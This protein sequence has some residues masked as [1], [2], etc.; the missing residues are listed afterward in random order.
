MCHLRGTFHVTDGR[1]ASTFGRIK[2]YRNR[3]ETLLY[4][5]KI[6][7]PIV[8]IIFAKKKNFFCVTWNIWRFPEWKKECGCRANI[9]SYTKKKSKKYNQSHSAYGHGRENPLKIIA[10]KTSRRSNADS[11]SIQKKKRQR[12]KKN[13]LG[14]YRS[15]IYHIVR[16]CSRTSH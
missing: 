8:P 9:Y 6:N 2:M 11:F 12:D 10:A 13:E 7:Y 5:W 14:E 3:R 1:D 4:F 16:H 15:R